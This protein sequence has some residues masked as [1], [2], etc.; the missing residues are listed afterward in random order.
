VPNREGSWLNAAIIATP[1]AFAS[2]YAGPLPVSRIKGESAMAV[3]Q[4]SEFVSQ[5][6]RKVAE[7]RRAMPQVA[8][9]FSGLAKYAI[10]PGG[11]GS[12]TKDLLPWP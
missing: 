8:A 11:L 2:R 6:D 7:L 9:Q 5:T 12:K 10:A 4:W 1:A 3:A